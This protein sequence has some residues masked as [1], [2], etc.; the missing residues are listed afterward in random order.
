MSRL[1]AILLF[2]VLGVVAQT[3][4]AHKPSDS[5]LKLTVAGKEISGQWDIALRDLDFA[6]GLDD[7]GDGKLTWGEVRAHHPAISAY[8]QSRL[9]LESDRGPC[10]I[11]V[12]PQLVDQHSDGVY[13]VLPFSA[14]CAAEI[15]DLAVAYR[16]FFDLDKQHKGLISVTRGESITAAIF[17]PDTPT[18]KLR[19]AELSVWRTFAD[20]LVEGIWHIGVGVDHILFLLSLLLPAVLVFQHQRWRPQESFRAA[21]VDVVKIVTAFTVAHSITLSLA[22]LGVVQ[23]PSRWVESVIALSVVAAAANNLWPIVQ[24][25][26]WSVAF[27]FGLIHGFGFASVLADLGLPQNALL[28]ALLSFNLGVELGQL[29]IASLFLPLAFTLRATPFYRHVIFGGGSAAIALLAMAWLIERAF[30]LKFMPI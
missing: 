25:R 20:Y 19:L 9:S 16:L 28:V 27:A 2:I 18:V 6:I 3:S 13:A 15:T 5:Y 11:V 7:N 1:V 17:T 10:P 14:Q 4:W 30:G 22:T 24:R 23:L 21:F 29:S 8:A 26:R 12:G